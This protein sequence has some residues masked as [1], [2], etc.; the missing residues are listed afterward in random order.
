MA[1]LD[2]QIDATTGSLR[3]RARFDNPDESLFPNQFVNIRLLLKTLPDALSVPVDT[4]Q[5]GNQG[6]YVYKILDGKAVAPARRRV[7]RPEGLVGLG[8][9]DLS[10][11][12]RNQW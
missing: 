10:E 5:F 4:V 3:V 2:N 6:N 12:W 11:I 8:W 7:I 9:D 1:T